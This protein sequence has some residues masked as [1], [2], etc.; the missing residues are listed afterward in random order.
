V[1][2]FFESAA[3]PG[4]IAVFAVGGPVPVCAGAILLPLRDDWA[5]AQRNPLGRG[6]VH[7]TKPEQSNLL[8]R[9][10]ITSFDRD[11]LK[12]LLFFAEQKPNDDTKYTVEEYRNKLLK[13]KE[14]E[15]RPF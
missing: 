12:F 4:D 8:A 1:F 14:Q 13:G 2:L 3:R 15:A 5:V 10:L 9:I 6:K 11:A 7:R